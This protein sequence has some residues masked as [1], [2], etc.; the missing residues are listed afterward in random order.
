YRLKNKGENINH[1]RLYRVYTA[2][3]LNIR[4]RS[5]K[6]LPERVKLPLVLPTAPNQCWSLDFMSDALSDGR[7]FR[8]LNIIDDYNR[9][10]LKIEVDTSLPALREY[11][12]ESTPPIPDESTPVARVNNVRD[13]VPLV[14]K[15][16]TFFPSHRLALESQSGGKLSA[17][18]L[19]QQLRHYHVSTAGKVWRF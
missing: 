17:C 16:M 11:S 12:E 1:K 8:V 2:M 9:E 6:R 10:S 15:L 13:D 18:P 3:H 14:S 7:K 5:K 4:R 19:W